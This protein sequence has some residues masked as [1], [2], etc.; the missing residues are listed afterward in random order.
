MSPS[1]TVS[2]SG[3]SKKPRLSLCSA[4]DHKDKRGFFDVPEKDTD[5]P[6]CLLAPLCPTPPK[7]PEEGVREHWPIPL[8]IEPTNL[9]YLDSEVAE[10]KCHSFLRVFVKEVT[11]G[12][13]SAT[14]KKLCDGEKPNDFQ[15]LGSGTCYNETFNGILMAEMN[16]NC[17]GT[18]NCTYEIPTVPLT[19]DCN[20]LRRET[21]IEYICGKF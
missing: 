7:A 18:F 3:T 21:K 20:G 14:A 10:L 5:W 2:F 11:Y 13:D 1:T 6:R 16:S 8:A 9:C 4:A 19:T 17:L 15:S 12:R